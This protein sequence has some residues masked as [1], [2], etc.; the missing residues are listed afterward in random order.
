MSVDPAIKLSTKGSDTAGRST[1][2]DAISDQLLRIHD[3]VKAIFNASA[4]AHE[5]DTVGNHRLGFPT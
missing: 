5:P 3:L 1:A 2:S 4:S